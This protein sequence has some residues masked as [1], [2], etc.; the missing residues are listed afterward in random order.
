MGQILHGGATTTHAARAAIQRSKA[1]AKEPAARYQLN[2]KTVAKWKKRNIVQDAAIPAMVRLR[3]MAVAANHMNGKTAVICRHDRL[4][5]RR[6][7]DSPNSL[8]LSK[9]NNLSR[10]IA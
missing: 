1:T 2:P 3:H 8:R 9:M 10:V 5:P 7:Q 4:R 6:I